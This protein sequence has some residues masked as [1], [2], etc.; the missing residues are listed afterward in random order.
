MT[1]NM[2]KAQET[3][4]EGLTW[5]EWQCAARMLQ[6]TNVTKSKLFEAWRRGEDPTEYASVARSGRDDSFVTI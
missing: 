6:A 5:P 1:T 2:K 3:N 4:Q